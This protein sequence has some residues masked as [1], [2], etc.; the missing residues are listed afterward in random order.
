MALHNLVNEYFA[1]KTMPILST[2]IPESQKIPKTTLCFTVQSLMDKSNSTDQW[3]F[4]SKNDER[5]IFNYTDSE[6][7]TL[8]PPVNKFIT[9]C[10]LRNWSTFEIFQPQNCLDHLNIK[11]FLTQSYIC[12]SVTFA[13]EKYSFLDLVTTPHQRRFLYEFSLSPS[14]DRVDKILPLVHFNDLPYDEMLYSHELDT[15]GDQKIL[16]SLTYEF[17]EFFRLPAPYDTRCFNIKA[18]ICHYKCKKKFLD[19]HGFKS[20]RSV[21]EIIV[22]PRNSKVHV[23]KD[24]YADVQRD[25][26]SECTKKCPRSECEK[27]VSVTISSYP[28]KSSRNK[29]HFQ[30]E[31]L[32]TSVSRIT[33][34]EKTKLVD[35]VI[36]GLSL[37]G[38]WFGTS[39]ISCVMF[40]NRFFVYQSSSS[41]KSQMR[42]IRK[43]ILRIRRS[44]L[45]YRRRML[46]V[47][48][49]TF[50]EFK[51]EKVKKNKKESKGCWLTNIKIN[52]LKTIFKS[53][54]FALCLLEVFNLVHDYLSFRTKMSIELRIETK[55]TY[56][57][58]SFCF[59]PSDIFGVRGPRKTLD[60]VESE[61]KR[62]A[63]KTK[64]KISSLLGRIPSVDSVIDK[65][66]FR[67][68]TSSVLLSFNDSG[69]CHEIFTVTKYYQSSLACYVIQTQKETL[70]L[71][72]IKRHWNHPGVLY[73]ISLSN[74][75]NLTRLVHMQPI[76]SLTKYPVNSGKLSHRMYRTKQKQLHLLSF[77]KFEFRELP[78]PYDTRC[79]PELT[80]K[81]SCTEKCYKAALKSIGKM[82]YSELYKSLI[83]RPMLTY[84][85]LKNKTVASKLTAAEEKCEGLCDNACDNVFIKTL[86][87]YEYKSE[88]ELEFTVTT[89]SQPL[90]F[91]EAL[92]VHSFNEMMYQ[93]ACCIAFWL[94]LSLLKVNPVELAHIGTIKLRVQFHLQSLVEIVSQIEKSLQ[95]KGKG[96][97]Q[98]K[99]VDPKKKKYTVRLTVV[100]ICINLACLLGCCN[101]LAYIHSLYFKYPTIIDTRL[102]FESNFSN[103]HAT[104]CI[105]L[106]DLDIEG[107]MTSESILQNSPST[108]E[109]IIE[110]GH[111]GFKFEG[112]WNASEIIKKRMLIDLDR[113][114]LC[115]QL[116]TVQK[117]IVYG[118]VCYSIAPVQGSYVAEYKTK[119]HLTS[120]GVMMYFTLSKL[121]SSHNLTISISQDLP[122]TSLF[123]STE[124]QAVDNETAHWYWIS[125]GK[126]YYTSIDYP[127]DSGLFKGMNRE[128]CIAACQ[129]R[130][131]SKHGFFSSLAKQKQPNQL[132]PEIHSGAKSNL[133]RRMK[134]ECKAKCKVDKS[135]RRET[136]MYTRTYA[137][138]PWGEHFR[139]NG[140]ISYWITVT[141][142]LVVHVELRPFFRIVD[143]ILFVGTI[144]SIWFGF[145]VM[146]ITS[147]V[148]R[149]LFGKPNSSS[150]SA[151]EDRLTWLESYFNIQNQATN[152]A[153][154]KPRPGKR[155]AKKSLEPIAFTKYVPSAKG[156]KVKTVPLK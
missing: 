78:S 97:A 49:V 131:M 76:L 79:N 96:K 61:M 156:Q 98:A 107:N 22:Q 88:A 24:K 95:L 30:T 46:Y 142:Y 83:S 57:Y 116:F 31:T 59:R 147:I 104:F 102:K 112:I 38:I 84:N 82:P 140:T 1:Y 137:D 42:Q 58:L 48:P 71:L 152:P 19:S 130:V 33:Y 2:Y 86:H 113:K 115:N 51:S 138:G 18:R 141:D 77:A 28:Q 123:L 127:Y 109:V 17:F 89:S 93:V 13:S 60:K 122:T 145:S 75:L 52:V 139:K 70:D 110:C 94:G 47:E 151:F 7:L 120:T 106:L 10:R 154:N 119:L 34:I 105:P 92:P 54:V 85:D 66:R 56:P 27:T 132:M 133:I 149:T 50:V 117:Y 69:D 4:S 135:Q 37:I 55:M 23:Y 68:V 118:L 144:L 108:S 63:K 29:F 128:K 67:P 90:V 111:R 73:S 148:Y 3:F 87:S 143:L 81:V 103:F 35:C 80:S 72:K 114:N 12:Y 11:K 8:L 62:Y 74:R 65:C 5:I 134:L 126:Y 150:L 14:F 146:E 6:L 36:R 20:Y 53:L 43:R 44:Y 64:Y 45:M 41:V 91:F 40:F 155:R 25:A 100:K 153:S 39:V 124:T 26:V 136:I 9:D 16:F 99:C 32:A 101:H 129:Q 125:Y 21:G 121:L 15:S